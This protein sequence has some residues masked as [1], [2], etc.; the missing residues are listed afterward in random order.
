M[1]FLCMPASETFLRRLC[2]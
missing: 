2:C 1:I